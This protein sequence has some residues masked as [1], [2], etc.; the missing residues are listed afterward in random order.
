VTPAGDSTTV[1]AV[2]QLLLAHS[3]G[4]TKLTFV[5]LDGQAQLLHGSAAICCRRYD[6]GV[7]LASS[8]GLLRVIPPERPESENVAAQQVGTGGLF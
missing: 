6:G 5:I 8:H 1:G 3:D 7:A 2:M 4:K